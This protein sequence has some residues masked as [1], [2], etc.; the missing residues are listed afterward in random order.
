MFKLTKEKDRIYHL[1]FDSPYDC[2]MAF[3]RYQ[4]YYESENPRFYRK[5]FTIASYTDWYVKHNKRN[6]TGK[7]T[8]HEDWSGFNFQTKIIDEVINLG[9][10]DPNHYDTLMKGIL[11]M[12]KSNADSDDCYIIGT[13]GKKEESAFI[14]EMAHALFYTNELYRTKIISVYESQELAVRNFLSNR[15]M[16]AGYAESSVI[17]EVQAFTIEGRFNFIL[18]DELITEPYS[19]LIN[20]IKEVYD[21]LK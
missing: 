5:A 1:N 4:E 6:D 9:I 13:S 10:P 7:F 19:N 20:Q 12:I 16:E 14:H 8:Y 11:E 18:D 17:D 15:L 2:A 3:L 21:E